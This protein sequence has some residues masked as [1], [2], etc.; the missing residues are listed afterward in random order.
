MTQYTAKENRQKKNNNHS[1]KCIAPTGNAFQTEI[2]FHRFRYNSIEV[3]L[4]DWFNQ[5][6][7]VESIKLSPEIIL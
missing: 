7:Q 6:H 2:K 4:K 5:L 1:I 3:L